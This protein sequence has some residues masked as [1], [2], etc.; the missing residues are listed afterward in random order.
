MMTATL[1]TASL[2][3]GGV[4][5]QASEKTAGYVSGSDLTENVTA[6]PVKDQVLP[7]ENQY[8]YQKDELAA[9]CH[10]GPNTFNEV[11]WGEN[12]GDKAP[13]EIFTLKD[14]FDAETMVN[15]LKEAG[16]KKL[17]V[18]AKHHDGFCIW[19]S[20]YTDY[21]VAATNY[22][23]GNGD[24]LEE[25]SAACT[26]A[27]MDMGLYLSPWDIHDPSYGYKDENGNPTTP[28]KDVKDYNEY[29][30]NQL[31][32]ILGNNKYGNGGRFVEVWMDGAKGSGANAQEYD[33]EQ[34]FR[35]IQLYEGIG[36]G[37]PADCMLFGAQ[38]YTTVRWIGNENG[39]AGKNTWSKSKVDT[40][41]H[42]INSNQSGDCTIGFKDGNKWTV[43][44]ADARI[45]SG[46]F[47]G[48]KKKTPK[49]IKDLGDMYFQSVGHNATLLL[50]VPP[51]SRGTI[52]TAILD[53][54]KEFG[55]NIKET[56]SVN[57]AA[58]TGV[59]ISASSVRGNSKAYTPDHVVDGDDATYW[60]TN[61]GE[62]S[63]SLLIDFGSIK[64]FDVV[65]I[66]EAIQF[67]QR[68]DHYKIEYRKGTGGDWITL[69]EGETIGAKRL[70][71]VGAV[72][73]RQ[74]KI[75]VK[76]D[77]G[78]VPVL[79][80]AGIYKASKSFE[81]A[82]AAPEGMDVID[83]G[84][85]PDSESNL[86]FD[87]NG[88]WHDESGAG[89]IGGTNKWAKEGASLNLKFHGTKVYLLGTVDPGHGTVQIQI[90]DGEVITVD[91]KAGTRATGQRWYTSQDLEDKD[92]T[93][94]LQV[95]GSA[96][97]IE[98]AYVINNG[99]NGMIELEHAG[100]QMN[101]D[102]TIDV[103]INR[104][105]GTK[106]I[107][108]AVLQPNPGTAIQDDYDTENIPT[109]IFKDGEN[110]ATAQVITKRNTNETGD[111]FFSIELIDARNGLIIG[112]QN[113]AKV[114]IK[115]TESK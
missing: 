91:T 101:E 70:C 42:T 113:K 98:A 82:G 68:I 6:G 14:D 28:D 17:I 33:F 20:A 50:N 51:N 106:G 32:E 5:V 65:S 7:D 10:F 115:D 56:F 104:V 1:V 3:L 27:D 83:I 9:F 36:A 38:D 55:D 30:D 23:N 15:A 44:E 81:V 86:G 94:K 54:L 103:V 64:S 39:I 58:G 67:G 8:K 48:T 85:I 18:T 60:T 105:G 2:G 76:T 97:G 59:E 96:V 41:K 80:E 90:D 63:G 73:G 11:E 26:A 49:S 16:F 66:E 79:S 45:T 108:S 62:N 43:P 19:N 92:H 52:D 31:K 25:I 53:R 21:D 75:T 95:T 99:G 46:W 72:N 13:S 112:F 61:D 110:R 40:I 100:Y 88:T 35:T 87:F 71:R 57:L 4:E 109:V 77:V 111:L 78:K 102:E 22:K 107:V 89:F 24:I 34:W 37:Y 74:V 47:W 29:Y 12:Y 69:E 84:E 93:L 114:I